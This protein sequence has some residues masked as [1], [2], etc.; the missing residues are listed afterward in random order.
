GPDCLLRHEARGGRFVGTATCEVHSAR[1]F[2]RRNRTTGAGIRG[3]RRTF[4]ARELDRL[5]CLWRGSGL[6]CW[7]AFAFALGPSPQP[8]KGRK[9]R[10]TNPRTMSMS[11]TNLRDS[12]LGILSSFGFRH[13]S[14][15]GIMLVCLLSLPL[16]TRAATIPGR[17]MPAKGP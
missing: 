13:S 3:G 2:D 12:G 6:F 8:R 15:V 14:F 9:G 1:G 4:A 7:R 17:P 10:E 16:L 5:L 11:T